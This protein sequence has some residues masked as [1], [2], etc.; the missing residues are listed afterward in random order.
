M[1]NFNLTKDELENFA[2]KIYEEACFGYLD[3]KESVCEKMVSDFLD[4]KEQIVSRIDSPM[5]SNSIT[6]GG[7]STRTVVSGTSYPTGLASGATVGGLS[8]NYLNNNSFVNN[9]ANNMT[10]TVTATNVPVFV[11]SVV[12]NEEFVRTEVFP[13]DLF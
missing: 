9:T 3:L 7:P 8:A 4:G 6:G 1:I 5:Y 10:Y 12:R 2:K 11:D 13:S